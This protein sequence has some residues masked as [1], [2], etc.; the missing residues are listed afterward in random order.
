MREDG[1]L[2]GGKGWK[3]KLYNRGEWKKILRMARNLHILHMSME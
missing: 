1:R 2:A 3:E